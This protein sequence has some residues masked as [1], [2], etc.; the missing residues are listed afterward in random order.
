MDN[1][2]NGNYVKNVSLN[3]WNEIKTNINNA[4]KPLITSIEKT[5]YPKKDKASVVSAQNDLNSH[6]Y[7]D[8]QGKKL[9]ID[10]KWGEK[11]NES[12]SKARIHNEQMEKPSENTRNLQRGLNKYGITDK[13]GNALKEDGI[14]GPLTDSASYHA[15]ELYK[16]ELDKINGKLYNDKEKVNKAPS[17]DMVNTK[18]YS[19]KQSISSKEN[20]IPNS[21]S[22]IQQSV[23][24]DNNHQENS[25][26]PGFYAKNVSNNS[27]KVPKFDIPL[28]YKVTDEDVL[29]YYD[30][31]RISTLKK[32]YDYFISKGD[33]LMADKVHKAAVDI[34]SSEIY[35]DK[36]YGKYY[37]DNYEYSKDFDHNAKNDYAVHQP[38]NKFDEYFLN[39]NF[40]D[41]F[42]ASGASSILLTGL[43]SIPY[44]N[45]IM[46]GLVQ[47]M[48]TIDDISQIISNFVDLDR[49]VPG[50][51]E[52]D[53]PVYI[54]DKW[55]FY[56]P[57]DGTVIVE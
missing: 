3:K 23:L 42:I 7:T 35:N 44:I 5:T 13:D 14:L 37:Y 53:I 36:G 48:P 57:S 30:Y 39:S 24:Y 41:D 19:D 49:C 51:K 32:M 10:G 18:Y 33:I 54:G 12:Y 34:R 15:I 6:G 21:K 50:V 8:M 26:S 22:N 28:Q 38:L 17:D 56:R 46:P 27:Q 9:K 16:K 45:Q 43:A 4:Y 20:S 25:S 31:R 11:T 29:T 2:L 40:F 52:G 1:F 55:Y 47:Y